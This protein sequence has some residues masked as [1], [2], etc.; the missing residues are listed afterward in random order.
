MADIYSKVIDT[1]T[2]KIEK[3]GFDK[4]QDAKA[5]RNELNKPVN[6]KKK[7]DDPYLARFQMTVIK[8]KDPILGDRLNP[9]HF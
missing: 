5:V 3:A 8:G 6:E 1:K 9:L 7:K 4:K 2:G